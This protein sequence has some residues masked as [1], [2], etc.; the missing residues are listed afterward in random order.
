MTQAIETERKYVL[1]RGQRLPCFD[2]VATEGDEVIQELLSIYYDTHDC[3]LNQAGKLIRRRTGS[4]D[5][6][7][8]AKLPTDAPDSRLEIQ[9]PPGGERLPRQLREIVADE[10]GEDALFPV[11]EVRT[12]RRRLE[13]RSPSGELMAYVSTDEVTAQVNGSTR[14][15]IEAEVE[16]VEASVDFLDQV[17]QVL[18]CAGVIRSGSGSKLSQALS[19]PVV[20]DD[21]PAPSPQTWQVIRRYLADQVGL[22]QSLEPMVIAESLDAV[23]RC[24]VATRRLRCTLDTF[25]G[26]FHTASVRSLRQELRQHAEELG[27]LRD[28]AVVE[29]RLAQAMALLPAE[30]AAQAAASTQVWAREEHDRAHAALLRWMSSERY[31][32]MQLA[33]EQLLANPPLDWMAF[34]PAPVLLPGMYES[35]V[36]K[37]RKLVDRAFARPAD[38]TRWHEVRKAAKAARYGAELLTPLSDEA[39]AAAPAWAEVTGSL[40]E[41]QDA[42]ISDQVIAELAWLATAAGADRLPFDD[43][44]SYTDALRRDALVNAR[45]AL[46]RALQL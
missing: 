41:V 8:Q 13:L 1:A 45:Q 2:T 17:D 32:R 26:A 5:A 34:E 9:L 33:L 7:W 21:E 44:R 30:L 15:W 12:H 3:R 29:E 16:L 14:E 39:A 24:R 10:V 18:A 25:D 31:L 20:P 37:V 6:G 23:H 28:V 19:E 36:S 27:A 46:G 35:A 43:L 11:A 4:A 42:V 40:G 38:M 22:L